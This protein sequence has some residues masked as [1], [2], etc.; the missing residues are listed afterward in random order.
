MREVVYPAVCRLQLAT[1]HYDAHSI[2]H[3]FTTYCWIMFLT[4]IST[5]FTN[6]RYFCRCVSDKFL[7][8]NLCVSSVSNQCGCLY[9]STHSWGLW[10]NCWPTTISTPFT[11]AS[12]K[13]NFHKIFVYVYSLYH[14]I[15]FMFCIRHVRL[16]VYIQPIA[17]KLITRTIRI[18]Y[19][20]YH[21]VSLKVP[22]EASIDQRWIY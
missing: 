20:N 18:K 12:L 2:A 9:K 14:F 5:T 4:Q 21:S 7:H 17:F 15:Y 22:A 13:C 8:P 3:F 16:C 19:K 11:H 6:N 10:R 1:V